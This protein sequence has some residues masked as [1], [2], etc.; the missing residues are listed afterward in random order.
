MKRHA[1]YMILLLAFVVRLYNVNSPIL[2]YHSWRQADTAAIAR[3][4]HEHGYNLFYPQI[5]WGGNTAG[6]VETEFQ[7]YPFVVALFYKMFGV[8]E[9]LGRFLSLAFSLVA[10]YALY[11]LVR[12]YINQSVALWTALVFSIIPLNIHFSRAFMPE[13]ALIMCSVL[14]VYLFSQWITSGK[15]RYFFLSAIFVGLACLIKIPTLY[16]GL[17]L[18]YLAWLKFDRRTFA[19]WPLWLYSLLVFIPTVLWY[20]HAHQIYLQYGLTFG[21]WEYGTDK[22]GNWELLLT[23]EFYNRILFKSIA[24]RHL[25]WAGFVAFAIGLF[26]KRTSRE[27]RVF[28]FWL[29][30]IAVY[31]IVAFAI[32]AAVF[33][34]KTFSRY[35]SYSRFKESSAVRRLVIGLVGLCAVCIPILSC[36][37]Y[38][39]YLNAEDSSSP[40]YSLAKEVQQK[41]EKDGLIIAVDGGDPTLLYLTHR[42]GWLCPAD[43]IDDA[44]IIE[45]KQNGAKYVVG[46]K[47]HFGSTPQKQILS[48]LLRDYHIIASTDDYFILELR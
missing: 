26:I 29:I 48:Q 38:H 17:P 33:V 22:W 46:E 44:S 36:Y 3:N 12:K 21:I 41:T 27:E 19:Q 14:G 8:R 6:Y 37:R 35:L 7:I 16:L 13:S 15:W 20:Y 28:D 1:V 45:G 24:E 34:G 9:F 10:I 4:F 18:L 5:D 30:S 31:F 23:P 32:P 2:G 39:T 47:R 40:K 42:K 11:L 43:D 25:T